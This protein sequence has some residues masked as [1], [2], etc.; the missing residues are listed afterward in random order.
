MVELDDEGL[1]DDG[2]REM[3]KRA[4]SGCQS[5]REVL[6]VIWGGEDG[7]TTLLESEG[8]SER[9]GE[10]ERRARKARRGGPPLSEGKN[11]A[12]HHAIYQLRCLAAR[13]GQLELCNDAGGRRGGEVG[14]LHS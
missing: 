6:G 4:Q 5:R 14:L 3:E 10:K 1:R 12:A 13:R 9:K 2:Y 7:Q 8:Q 11:L